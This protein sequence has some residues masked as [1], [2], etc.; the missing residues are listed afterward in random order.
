[1]ACRDF[2]TIAGNKSR[3]STLNPKNNSQVSLSFA[4]PQVKPIKTDYRRL[5]SP[6]L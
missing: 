1:M 2:K 5:K 4:L 3:I 6:N